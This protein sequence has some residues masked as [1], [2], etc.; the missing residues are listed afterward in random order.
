MSGIKIKVNHFLLI[1]TILLLLSISLSS[2][3]FTIPYQG[4]IK[5]SGVAISGNYILSFSIYTNTNGGI[6]LW[7]SDDQTVTLKEG[8]FNY[9]LGSANTF[10][11]INWTAGTKYLEVAFQNTTLAP[12]V[13]L[14]GSFYAQYANRAGG[15]DWS[16][17]TNIP[18]GFADGT[19]AGEI[20]EISSLRNVP[21]TADRDGN[22]SGQIEFKIGLTKY[23]TLKN[24]GM[25]FLEQSQPTN[26]IVFNDEI[27]DTTPFVINK[28]GNVGIGI[29]IPTNKLDVNGTVRVTAFTGDG[30]GAHRTNRYDIHSR[31]RTWA[32]RY[33]LH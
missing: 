6:A 15:V 20:V 1:L 24:N 16:N 8:V 29:S 30:F 14:G 31:H 33:N 26:V 28:N 17:I 12:R 18:A 9:L 21:I 25:L 32:K 11:N 5:E 27:G 19:D 22:S 23:M 13:K 2:L 4:Y 10:T 3:D 7:S